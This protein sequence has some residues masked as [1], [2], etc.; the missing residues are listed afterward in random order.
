MSAMVLMAMH[1]L[2]AQSWK[3]KL[4]EI[5]NKPL[6]PTG[7]PSKSDLEA[8]KKV[9]F[10]EAGALN[11]QTDLVDFGKKEVGKVLEKDGQDLLYLNVESNDW[12]IVTN[13]YTGEILYRWAKGAF[14]Q[15]NSDG[16]CMLQGCIIK[17]Q[18]NGSDYNSSMFGGIIHGQLPYG[19][20]M[21]CENVPNE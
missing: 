19:Q 2:S 21:A 16:R 17:Q 3:D 9:Q 13:K 10:P 18:Y 20:Y 12:T 6:I 1:Q 7:K 11:A 14:A 15:K 4:D 5:A 8:E